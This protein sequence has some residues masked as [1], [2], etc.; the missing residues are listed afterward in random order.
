MPQ[1]ENP[2]WGTLGIRL[3]GGGGGDVYICCSR[4]LIEETLD[5]LGMGG[6]AGL[7][8]AMKESRAIQLME[9]LY[10]AFVLGKDG[11]AVLKIP[12]ASI[13]KSSERLRMEVAAMKAF[14]HP[15]LI[16]LLDNDETDPPTWLVMEFHPGGDLAKRVAH[17]KGKTLESLE[18]IRPI[19]E[20]VAGFHQLGYIHRDIKPK[21]IFTDKDGSLI[22]GDFGIVFPPESEDQRYTTSEQEIISRDWVPDWARFEDSSPQPKFDVFM[23]AK[24]LYFMITGGLKVLASRFE[25]PRFDIRLLEPDAVGIEDVHAF[26]KRCITVE[27]ENCEFENAG[28]M[29]TKLDRLIEVLKGKYA[30]QLVFSFLSAHSTTNVQIRADPENTSQYPS[31]TKIRVFLPRPATV[32]RAFARVVF[33]SSDAI[34]LSFRINGYRSNVI[35]HQEAGETWSNE[36]LLSRAIAR[37]VHTLD[38]LPSC[39]SGSE[40]SAFMLYAE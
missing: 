21:N 27:E 40:L 9:R 24:V 28:E 20:G 38:V 32:F 11:I 16:Q 4:K 13:H 34:N 18:A 5:F 35:L 1:I 30:T 14:R 15:G 36:I 33:R 10:H 19:V 29:L 22:L 31:L 6:A 3:N 7:A 25:N 17:Y 8:P 2:R 39:V 26:L 23:L 37:G 12:H